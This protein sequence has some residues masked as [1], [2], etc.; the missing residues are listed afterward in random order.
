ME[1]WGFSQKHGWVYLDRDLPCNGP[2][3]YAKLIFVCCRTGEVILEERKNWKRPLYIFEKPYIEGLLEKDRS[4]L[5]EEVESYK[6]DVADLKSKARNVWNLIKDQAK[7]IEL[8]SRINYEWFAGLFNA[9]EHTHKIEKS[10]EYHSYFLEKIGKP[11]LGYIDNAVPK[12]KRVTHCYSC[13]QTLDNSVNI[14]CKACS[15]IICPCGACGCGWVG[16]YA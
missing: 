15:W 5:I 1:W 7:G 8:D 3:S 10:K 4:I 12:M 9:L 13:K 11:N 6:R 14:E 16:R 2:N